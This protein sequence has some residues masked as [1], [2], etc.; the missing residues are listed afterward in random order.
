MKLRKYCRQTCQ[1][2]KICLF[3]IIEVEM[4]NYNPIDEKF[5]KYEYIGT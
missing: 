2:L 3:N 1:Y 4:F 5:I